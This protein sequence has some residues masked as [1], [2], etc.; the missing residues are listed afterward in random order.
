MRR[1]QGALLPIEEAILAAGLDLRRK[2]SGE[3]HGFAIAKR[4]KEVGD[5]HQL[6]AHGTLYKALGRLEAAGLLESRWEEAEMALAEARPRR[7]QYRVTGLGERTLATFV[8]EKRHPVGRPR[9]RL[10]SP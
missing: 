3:F 4:I 6:T 8:S 5:A 1:K 10:A 2:G 7:R 9:T